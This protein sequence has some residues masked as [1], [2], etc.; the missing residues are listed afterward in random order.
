MDSRWPLFLICGLCMAFWWYC[1]PDSLRVV[2]PPAFAGEMPLCP[3]PPQVE[4]GDPPLQTE[5]PEGLEPFRL[6]VATLEPLAGFSVDALVLSREN[7]RY[8]YPAKLAPLDLLLGW[9]P[10]EDE[11]VRSRLKFSQSGRWGSYAWEG[12]PPLPSDEISR[13]VSNMHLI[14]YDKKVARELRRVKKGQRVRLDGWLVEAKDEDGWT[15]RSSLTREDTGNGACEIVYVCA[16]TR[17]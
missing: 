17:Y 6:K 11:K 15:W 10:M 4:K 7:Y 1:S 13:N 5:V 12:Q 16:V 2:P 3:L 8:D 9:G 14:A